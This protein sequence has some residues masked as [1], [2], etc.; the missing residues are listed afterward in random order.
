LLPKSS[1]LPNPTTILKIHK[2]QAKVKEYQQQIDQLVYK[3]YNLTDEEIKTVE[4][5]PNGS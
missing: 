3:F 2:K 5:F 4:E 1:P